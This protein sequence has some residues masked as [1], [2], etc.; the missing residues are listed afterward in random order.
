MQASNAPSKSAVPFAQS[1]TKNAIPVASQIGVTPGAAS[2]T[3]GFPPLTMTPVAAGGV[4]PYG[5]DFNGILNFL[6]AAVRWSQAGGRYEFD[7]AF[8]TAVGGY[9]KGAVLSSASGSGSWQNLADNNTTNPDDGGIGWVDPTAGRLLNVQ[10]FTSVGSVTYTPTTGTRSVVVEVQGGG[11]AGGGSQAATASTVSV[12]PGGNAGAYGKSRITSGFSGVTVTVGAGGAG[13][14]G[15]TGGNGGTSSFGSHL[16][17][18]GGQGALTY[19]AHP[20][21]LLNINSSAQSSSS[22]G[23]VFNAPGGRGAPG[24]ASGNLY[25]GSG[26]GGASAFGGGGGAVGVFA[27]STNGRAGAAPGSGGSGGTGGGSATASSGGSGAPGI[28][29]V[30]EYA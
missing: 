1:G 3:D 11:G 23:N 30:W 4:P 6:S 26:D 27:A 5:A 7:S 24:V 9:P 2:F 14:L 25:G 10:T 21:P 15:A 16:S 18:P 19:V 29:I 22:G 12:C 13:V 28:V 20:A 17:A 8:A